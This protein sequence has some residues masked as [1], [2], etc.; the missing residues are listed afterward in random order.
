VA[1]YLDGVSKFLTV[2]TL[3]LAP[4]LGLGAVAGEMADF[5]AVAA[6]DGCGVT[7]LITLLGH[8]V[9]RTA[10]TAGAGFS[11]GTL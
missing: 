4:V 6:R 8:V 9:G 3:H 1:A 2:L 11:R 5:L 10:V 7:W